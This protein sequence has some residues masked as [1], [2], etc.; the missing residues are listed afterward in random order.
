MGT[1]TDCFA[2]LLVTKRSQSSGRLTFGNF[3]AKGKWSTHILVGVVEAPERAQA[4]TVQAG[5]LTQHGVH[6]CHELRIRRLQRLGALPFDF[7]VNFGRCLFRGHVHRVDV[8]GALDSIVE[9]VRLL[10]T[11]PVDGITSIAPR[12]G[13]AGGYA[14]DGVLLGADPE[15]VVLAI[16]ARSPGSAVKGLPPRDACNGHGF[17]LLGH[18]DGIRH[19]AILRVHAPDLHVL[20]W[21]PFATAFIAECDRGVGPMQVTQK[22]ILFPFRPHRFQ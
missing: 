4:G 12:D 20:L 11:L 7:H 6:H 9:V 5:A 13:A 22:R 16:Y 19:D 17:H 1:A 18:H 15:H 2:F 21:L 8:N 14:D 3:L 10:R